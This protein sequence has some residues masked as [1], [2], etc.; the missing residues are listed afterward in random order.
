MKNFAGAAAASGF[1]DIEKSGL[2]LIE[3]DADNGDDAFCCVD[4]GKEMLEFDRYALSMGGPDNLCWFVFYLFVAFLSFEFEINIIRFDSLLSTGSS[5]KEGNL[6]LNTAK[7]TG[8][9][10]P[11][12]QTLKRNALC[13]ALP[14][15]VSLF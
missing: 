4:K 7:M 1:W 3:K 5:R 2:L 12:F 8:S 9:K 6:L 11:T 15:E 13:S 10:I 14:H